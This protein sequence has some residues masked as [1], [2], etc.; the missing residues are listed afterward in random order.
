MDLRFSD[1]R[2]SFSI[3][4]RKRA[5]LESDLWI[6]GFLSTFH[7]ER[8]RVGALA[9]MGERSSSKSEADKLSAGV[10]EQSSSPIYALRITDV[11][12]VSTTKG[13]HQLSI[14]NYSFSISTPL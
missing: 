1:L 12:D 6:Y 7:Y 4:L 9:G 5:K 10:S 11:T 3:S 13:N 8:L 2:I 14:I